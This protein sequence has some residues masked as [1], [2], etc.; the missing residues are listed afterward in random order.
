MPRGEPHEEDGA[1][2]A[3]QFGRQHGLP[4]LVEG[5]I[6]N[7]MGGGGLIE[8]PRQDVCRAD[9]DLIPHG[10]DG[11][12]P[13]PYQLGSQAQR[14]V[15]R[16]P[17]SLRHGAVTHGEENQLRLCPMVGQDAG[18]QMRCHSPALA[19]IVLQDDGEL[20]LTRVNPSM[21][22]KVQP[23]IPLLQGLGQSLQGHWRFE[24]AQTDML[25]VNAS[26]GACQ[27]EP[28][29]FD[30]ERRKP[31]ALRDVPRV[32]NGGQ[33][34]YRAFQKRMSP[35]CLHGEIAGERR[36]RIGGDEQT[37]IAHQLPGQVVQFG[38]LVVNPQANP[39]DG[40]Q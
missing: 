11:R 25:R 14:G 38:G 33:N 8:G 36:L 19:L 23:M 21:A 12:D 5:A 26:K 28:L 7:S 39:T 2:Y 27:D 37:V 16:G 31:V 18:E 29:A 30:I 22:H 40:T 35:G 15:L 1:G 4:G 32:G 3:R 24:E 10:D 6:G 9:A 20:G 34:T 17:G 13:R